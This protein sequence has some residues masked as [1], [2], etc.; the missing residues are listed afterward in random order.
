MLW[1]QVARCLTR[2]CSSGC[3]WFRLGNFWKVLGLRRKQCSPRP[4]SQEVYPGRAS[5]LQD[6]L[7]R[8][9]AR[10]GLEWTPR[11][12]LI[13]YS[14]NIYKLNLQAKTIEFLKY[15]DKT[16]PSSPHR[17]G[18]SVDSFNKSSHILHHICCGSDWLNSDA[19]TVQGVCKK[20]RP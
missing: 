14:Y 11:V 8:T 2:G 4:L 15:I 20:W 9:I 6:L 16:F 18:P 10:Q 5:L 7:W 3:T 13:C 19:V 1:S 12:H 17:R